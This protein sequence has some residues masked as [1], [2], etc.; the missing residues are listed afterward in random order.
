MEYR[1]LGRAGVKV[2]AI[3]VDAINS[4]AITAR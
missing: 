4:A 1:N 2:P 3:G